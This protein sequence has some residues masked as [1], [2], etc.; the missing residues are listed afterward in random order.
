MISHKFKTLIKS[1]RL[2]VIFG[3]IIS[4]ISA[5]LL[6]KIIAVFFAPEVFGN[7]NLQLAAFTLS[8]TI[9]IS[10]MIQFIKTNTNNFNLKIGYR[11]YIPVLLISLMLCYGSLFVFFNVNQIESSKVLYLLL[12]LFTIINSINAVVLDYQNITG[13]IKKFITISFIQK[14]ANTVILFSLVFLFIDKNS[15]LI[16][17]AVILSTTVSMLIGIV[18]FKTPYKGNFSISYLKFFKKY[19]IFAGPLIFMSIWG[20]LNNYFDRFAI[21]YFLDLKNVG[22]YNAAYGLGSKFFLMLSPIFIT[23]LVPKVYSNITIIKKKKA[24][25]RSFLFFTI[26]GLLLLLVIYIVYPIIGSIFLSESYNNGFYIIPG[27]ALAYFL[28]TASSLFETLFYSESKTNFILFSNIFTAIVNIGLNIF[29]I[30]LYGIKGA[31]IAT[32]ISFSLKLVL[33]FLLYKKI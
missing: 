32:I 14:I 23:L 27:I 19:S 15:E 5:I 33:T 31:M 6:G 9:F 1:D 2:F 10:P 7:Y 24:I 8:F 4:A 29:L 21:E 16:W 18:Q 20:W 25:K 13:Q 22:L 3:Q 11:Y 12:L 17:W 28:L 26:I 30:P